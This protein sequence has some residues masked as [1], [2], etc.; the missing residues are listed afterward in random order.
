MCIYVYI[1]IERERERDIY[2]YIHICNVN[3]CVC[4]CVCLCSHVLD[5]VAHVVRNLH[6]SDGRKHKKIAEDDKVK[7]SKDE[8]TQGCGFDCGYHGTWSDVLAHEKT[9]QHNQECEL[10]CGY[11]GTWFDVAAHEKVCSL[12]H[13]TKND[14][15]DG[16]NLSVF[17]TCGVCWCLRVYTYI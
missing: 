16:S 13:T 9:C 2:S 11:S 12:R 5:L 15:D 8:K 10:D 17:G 4:A 6:C 7:S 3:V 14:D 1:D